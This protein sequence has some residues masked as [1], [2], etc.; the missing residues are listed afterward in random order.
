MGNK[1][2]GTV[3][4]YPGAIIPKAQTDKLIRRL[5]LNVKT[6]YFGTISKI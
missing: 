3:I 4:Q 6:K 5:K 2:V 1:L